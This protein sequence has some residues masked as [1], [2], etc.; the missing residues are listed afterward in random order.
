MEVKLA[1]DGSYLLACTKDRHLFVFSNSNNSF[2][3]QAPRKI[4]FDNESPCSVSFADDNKSFLV[5]MDS[6]NIYQFYLPE[7]K[8]KSALKDSDRIYI[9]QLSAVF[10]LQVNRDVQLRMPGLLGGGQKVLFL[11]DYDGTIRCYQN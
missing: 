8:H 7:L 3:S 9:S 5:C 6:R 2:V 10:C 1:F 4:H 11:T